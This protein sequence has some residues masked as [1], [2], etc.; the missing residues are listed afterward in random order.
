MIYSIAKPVEVTDKN[1]NKV[2]IDPSTGIVTVA[3]DALGLTS[4]T[5]AVTA[6]GTG[7]YTGSTTAHI[8]INVPYV[9]GETG[10]AGGRIFYDKGNGD[11]NWRYL[12]LS[13]TI[14][15][16]YEWG[17]YGIKVGGLSPYIGQWKDEYKGNKG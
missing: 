3:P 9:I 12:E 6:T 11:D 5:Y 4:G 15:G 7:A 8:I 13:P 14:L 2:T 10:P 16:T 1:A 17:G